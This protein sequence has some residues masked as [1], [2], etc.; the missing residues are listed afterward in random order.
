MPLC[1]SIVDVIGETPLVRLR[2]LSAE[3]GV[4]VLAKLEGVNPAGSVK[5]RIARAMVDDAEQSGRLVPGATLIEP[6]SGNTGIALAMIAAAR[7]YRL[8]L[9]M[10]E[11]MSR[12]R[13]QLLRAYGADVLLTPGTLMRAAVEQAEALG[14]S[15]PGAVLLRQFE[16]PANPLAHERGTA[17]EIWRDTDGALDVLVAGIGT[18]GT[19][20]GVSRVLKRRLPGLRVVGVEPAGAAVLSG[21][22]ATGHHIQGIG[23]G[24]VPKVLDRSL[25]DEI[26]A[27]TEEESLAAVRRLAR[28]DGVLSGISSGAAVA[29][30]VRLAQRP[31][32]AGKRFV[33][34]LPDTGERYIST[35][36]F[37]VLS[38]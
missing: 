10:P 6:T 32:L 33:V 16:N 15:T 2:R 23:A 21:H 4:E 29:A 11:A 28:S 1:E 17:E 31:E 37:S 5:D 9:T 3:A 24:F 18:G 34:V 30:V 35:E 26:V 38:R 25:V 20:T 7:G 14:R 27:V 22:A 19:I 12:E 13:V 8:V 36:L